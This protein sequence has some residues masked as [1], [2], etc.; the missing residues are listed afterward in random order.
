MKTRNAFISLLVIIGLLLSMAGCTAGGTEGTT[1]PTGPSGTEVYNTA[2]APLEAAT[3]VTL[4]LLLTKTTQVGGDA[5]SEEASQTLTYGAIGTE[6]AIIALE[7]ET[8]YGVHGKNSGTEAAPSAPISYKETWSHGQLYTELKSLYYY[9]SAMDAETAAARFTP[10]ILLNAELYG[11]ITTEATNAG[12]KI[13]FAEATAA[14]SWAAPEEAILTE[15]SGTAML[16]AG[17]V[18]TEMNY[19]VTYAYGPAQIT[20]EV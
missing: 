13:T 6:N 1:A 10:V 7:E 20:L 5:F 3:D 4:E 16:D 14:E 2:K 8:T 11:S 12:T 15:A 18:L 19:T 17:G 9:S